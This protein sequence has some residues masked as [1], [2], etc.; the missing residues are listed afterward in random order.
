MADQEG[1]L[2]DEPSWAQRVISVRLHLG[3]TQVAFAEHLGV[4]INTIPQWEMRAERPYSRHAETFLILEAE[5]AEEEDG[6]VS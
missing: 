5:L 4:H 6:G 2:M 3:M 1:F